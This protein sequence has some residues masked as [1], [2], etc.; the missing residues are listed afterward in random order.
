MAAESG[1]EDPVVMPDEID[2]PIAYEESEA[3]LA[4]SRQNATRY[5]RLRKVI[6]TV[7]WEF[8]FFQAVRLL[9]RLQPDRQPIGRF[10]PPSQEAVRFGATPRMA[11]PASQIHGLTWPASGPPL[12]HV[13]FMGMTGPSGMMPLYYTEL[14][15]ERHRH[16]DRALS[17]F[18]DLFNHRIISL[19][20][21]AWEKYRVTVAYERNERDRFSHILMDA[22]GLGTAHLQDRQVIRDDS[23]LFYAGLLGLHTRPAASLRQVL[24]DYFD[25]PVEIEQLVGAWHT[26]EDNNQCKFD[27]ANTYSEQVGQG[28]IVGDEIWDQQSGV[29]IRLGPLTLKQYLD[30]LPTGT[31]YEPLQAILRFFSGWE[32]DYEVQLVLKRKQVPGCVLGDESDE[33]PMLGW[34]SWAKNIDMNRDPDDTILRV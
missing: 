19:F 34:V 28:A 33:A 24:W 26:L 6:E 4:S 21:Q 22:V 27:K 14:I 7:P 25:V 18:L 17:A 15:L 8:Q 30:F 1:T 2:E 31:A 9:E 29:R 16:K 10:V 23:I 5:A 12:M 13:N 20:Y 32:I 11:F 3:R